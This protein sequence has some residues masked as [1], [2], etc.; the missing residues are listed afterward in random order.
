MGLALWAAAPASAQYY[1]PLS[2]G[3]PSDLRPVLA[4]ELP[5][6][7]TWWS[8]SAPLPPAQ[9]NWC[10][11]RTGVSY[12][13]SPSLGANVV[14]ID[15][16]TTALAVPAI[17]PGI[18][19]AQ[20]SPPMPAAG[21][22]GAGRRGR[23]APAGPPPGADPK[24][25]WA[26]ILIDQVHAG[27]VD[28]VLHNATNTDANGFGYLWQLQ[29]KTNLSDQSPADWVPGRVVQ[30]RPAMTND[31]WF[32]ALPCSGPPPNNFYR[33]VGAAATNVAR[34]YPNNRAVGWDW[35]LS[36]TAIRPDAANRGVVTQTFLVELGTPL[37]TDFTVYY[38]S[39]G[40]ATN[41]ADYAYLP[42]HV[43]VPSGGIATVTVQP[44]Y[45]TNL[46]FDPL[47]VLTL[48][49]T[50]GCAVDPNFAS[51]TVPIM[52]NFSTNPFVIVANP[53]YAVP[54]VDYMPPPANSLLLS[55]CGD[56]SFG[57]V[58]YNFA[59]LHPN[60]TMAPWSSPS[61]LDWGVN[62]AAVKA[63]TNGFTTDETYFMEQGTGTIGRIS[64][65]GSGLN[66][67]WVS[68]PG[69]ND[70]HEVSD[71]YLDQTGLWGNS[72]LAVTS[73]PS[74]GQSDVWRITSQAS[75]S[76]LASDLPSWSMEGLLTLPDDP[77][78][79]PLAGA[80]LIGDETT[81]TLY[82]LNL[83]GTNIAVETWNL[84]APG[85]G[86]A[87]QTFLIV[88]TNQQNLYIVDVTGCYSSLVWKLPGSFFVSH[89]GDVLAIQCPEVS[90]CLQPPTVWLLRWNGSG[91]D[92]WCL[93]LSDL[94]SAP[95]SFY[96]AFTA[97]EKGVFAP[98]DIPPLD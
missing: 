59:L 4:S 91:F 21:G 29:S 58:P 18:A 52:D 22:G 76:P 94:G 9:F 36:S 80:V 17:T 78:Y 13:V 65:D 51:I 32:P 98:I 31:V 60:G 53:D 54:D 89:G 15:D 68:L 67:G 25:A 97:V 75:A 43:T 35:Q 39:S 16:P 24:G 34:A 50:N 47:A 42:G 56:P 45:R 57:P 44:Y 11:G 28:I 92:T 37:A 96:P 95:F 20:S 1:G 88:P 82:T 41:G 55:L 3:V 71:V 73:R 46:G 93:V 40:T 90:Q 14:F 86:V 2:Q 84:G 33:V 62:M 85:L 19:M 74:Q 77:R 23:P 64:A 87:G 30:G 27:T 69:E 83:V 61:Y 48:L 66:P 6:N 10:A 81:N 72:L 26:Q 38:T 70:P 79:G 63:T 8:L 49:P 7:A 12:Y 5:S